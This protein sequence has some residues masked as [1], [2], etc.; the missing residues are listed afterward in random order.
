MPPQQ[1]IFLRIQDIA[2]GTCYSLDE[3]TITFSTVTTGTMTEDRIC[4][5][6]GDG[7]GRNRFIV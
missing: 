4:D 3:F 6:D 1:T 2:S 7:D 5:A